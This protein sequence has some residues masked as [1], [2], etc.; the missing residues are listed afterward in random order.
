VRLMRR[1]V[2]VLALGG[3][4]ELS[5]EVLDQLDLEF[6]DQTGHP[7]VQQTLVPREQGRSLLTR[8]LAAQWGGTASAATRWLSGWST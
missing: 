3:N 4:S 5:R 1:A 6:P 8:Q 7:F 2:E